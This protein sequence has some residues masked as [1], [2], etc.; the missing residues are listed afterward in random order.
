MSD[1]LEKFQMRLH[2]EWLPAFCFAPRNNYSVEGFR[3]S[4]LRALDAFDAEWFLQAIDRRLVTH[5][6]GT[7]RAPLSSAVESIFWQLEKSIVPRPVTLWREPV[8]TI[9]AVARLHVQFGWPIAF[10]GMQSKRKWA[11]DLVGYGVDTS[12]ELLLCEVKKSDREIEKL[13]ALMLRYCAEEPLEVEPPKGEL[14]N[15]YRKVQDI[16][17]SWPLRVWLLGPGG[18]GELYGI[19][20]ESST[21]RFKMIPEPIENLA[22]RNFVD[23][24]R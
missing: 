12:R 5:E 23:S 17:I 4:S 16:R 20:R 15:A 7:F 11:F 14:Q 24:G 6:D 19:E 8:I 10:L 21:C 13:K 2:S 18:R 22:Y 3:T 1:A 9:G